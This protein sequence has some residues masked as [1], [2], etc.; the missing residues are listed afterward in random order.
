MVTSPQLPL[1]PWSALPAQ[2]CNHDSATATHWWN[3][4]PDLSSAQVQAFVADPRSAAP[5]LLK[6]ATTRLIYDLGSAPAFQAA[7]T[8]TEHH[9]VNATP[10]V[11]LTFLYSDGFGRESQRK[12]QAEPDASGAP[13]W[14]GTGWTIYNNKGQPVRQFEPFFSAT[15]NFEFDLRHGVS[16][17]LFYDPLG[18]VVATLKPDHSWEKVIQW[19]ASGYL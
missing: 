14:V 18:R 13:R 8:R 2:R 1:M 7:I 4:L 9:T 5:T 10:D 19:L 17:Y 6:G 16:P 15:H 12:F 3:F 11:F